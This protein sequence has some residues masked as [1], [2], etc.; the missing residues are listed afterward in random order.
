M[1][2]HGSA[3]LSALDTSEK[4]VGSLTCLVLARSRGNMIRKR[5]EGPTYGRFC[6][7]LAQHTS[8]DIFPMSPVVARYGGVI[9]VEQEC[10][11]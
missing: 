11:S 9:V 5:N 1:L 3:V 10:P 4:R 2:A 6:G 8:T 7:R